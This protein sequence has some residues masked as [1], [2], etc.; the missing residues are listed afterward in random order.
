MKHILDEI[1]N[2]DTSATERVPEGVCC[3]YVLEGLDVPLVEN[4]HVD[5]LVTGTS[6]S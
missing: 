6:L 2:L 3:T 4:L 5:S 1:N